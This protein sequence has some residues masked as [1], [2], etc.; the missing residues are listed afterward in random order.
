[1][2]DGVGESSGAVG[3]DKIQARRCASQSTF[4]GENKCLE[5]V[6]KW[7]NLSEKGR[8]ADEEAR[9]RSRFL[10]TQ[11]EAIASELQRAVDDAEQ[12]KEKQDELI[13][14]LK[15]HYNKVAELR[16]VER[17]VQLLFHAQELRFAVLFAEMIYIITKVKISSL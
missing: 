7:M 1:M 6:L 14:Q 15:M 9:K 2:S 11:L 12:H 13:S 17:S 3:A 4:F 16:N 10:R 5:G 8:L